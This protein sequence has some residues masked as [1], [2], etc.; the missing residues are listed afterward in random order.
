MTWFS[1]AAL[2]LLGKMTRGLEPFQDVCLCAM[3][4]SEGPAQPGGDPLLGKQND[5]DASSRWS[6]VSDPEDETPGPIGQ[7]DVERPGS[8]GVPTGRLRV[9]LSENTAFIYRDWIKRVFL[10]ISGEVSK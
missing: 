2:V 10:V 8:P 6:P 5:R 1:F 9:R 3:A 4:R 7:P